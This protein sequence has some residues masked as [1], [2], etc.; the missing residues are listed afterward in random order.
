MFNLNKLVLFFVG[1]V[2]Q[3]SEIHRTIM[4]V[5]AIPVAFTIMAYWGLTVV[6]TFAPAC[7]MGTPFNQIIQVVC[8]LASE[9]HTR[10]LL[11]TA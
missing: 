5:M 3:L 10:Q 6:K 8:S 11:I 2:L 1:L 9:I 7:P 4:V